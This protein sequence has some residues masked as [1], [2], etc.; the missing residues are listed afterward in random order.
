[1][2]LL[3]IGGDLRMHYAAQALQAAGHQVRT[4]GTPPLDNPFPVQED[5]AFAQAWLLPLPV[6]YGETVNASL[7]DPPTL[8]ALAEQ[9]RPGLTVYGGRIPPCLRELLE[10]AGAQVEDY[11]TDPVLTLENADL[12]AEGALCAWMQQ[13]R[14]AIAGRRCA[15]VGYG[16]IARGLCRRLTALGV[17]VTICARKETALTEARLAGCAVLPLEEEFVFPPFDAVFHTVPARIFSPAAFARLG[18]GVVYDLA[19]GIPEAPGAGALVPLRGVPGRYA[20][21]SAGEAIARAV[22]RCMAQREQTP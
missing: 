12:T 2:N 16:R 6:T 11:F 1:M 4:R 7:P 3:T 19:D 5:F 15:V 22:L 17:Q 21:R 10:S 8:H 18:V 20:P 9:A 14:T 13:S